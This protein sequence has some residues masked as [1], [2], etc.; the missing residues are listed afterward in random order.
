V[1]LAEDGE[2][3][4]RL[5]E[6]LLKR[7]GLGLRAVENGAEALMEVQKAR[8]AGQPFDLLLMD[9]QMPVLDGYSAVQR[10][11]ELGVRTP[12]MALTANAM[13]SDR[14][15]CLD[16]GCDEFCA[17]PIDFDQFFAVLE[18]CLDLGRSR[19]P[20]ALPQPMPIEK[21]E[22]RDEGF[23]QLVEQFVRELSDEVLALRAKFE[24][25]DLPGLARIAH[26]LKGSCGSYGFP[27][28]SRR[29]AELERCV[30]DGAASEAIEAA[31][32]EFARNC[33][34]VRS[35]TTV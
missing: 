12:I 13:T 29:A 20:A 19:T 26:Q 17:K 3:N 31:L 2:D 33:A 16:A 5:I 25:G 35:S 8:D 30:K 22:A 7:V 14:Q 10:L 21:A 4:R 11:R 15:R 24:Q 6:H 28:L 9:M 18:R 34:G 27:E 1:L 23:A 32:A